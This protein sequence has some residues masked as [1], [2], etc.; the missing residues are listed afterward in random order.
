MCES[1]TEANAWEVRITSKVVTAANGR[2]ILLN[3]ARDKIEPSRDGT[4]S[5]RINEAETVVK[6]YYI[7]LQN[8]NDHD[9]NV[10]RRT[11]VQA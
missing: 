2:A 4:Q 7:V 1:S 3:E 10:N 11:I 9:E 5:R 6:R 8:Q